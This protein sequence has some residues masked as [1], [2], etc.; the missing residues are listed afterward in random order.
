MHF[1]W[2]GCI[3]PENVGLCPNIFQT[4]IAT[5]LDISRYL[6]VTF[7]WAGCIVPENIGMCSNIFPSIADEGARCAFYPPTDL[8]KFAK[9]SKLENLPKYWQ[10]ALQIIFDAMSS[11]LKFPF[12]THLDSKCMKTK[13][14]FC[15]FSNSVLPRQCRA[16]SGT[17]IIAEK[18]HP[19]KYCDLL[20]HSSDQISLTFAYNLYARFRLAHLP[21]SFA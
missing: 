14:I 4:C 18:P 11:V 13:W 16:S 10:F 2:V 1:S 9:C 19:S 5:D 21:L 17:Q 20:S 8:P 3:V 15:E 12:S 7:S 6:F